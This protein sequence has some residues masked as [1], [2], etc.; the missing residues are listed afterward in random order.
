MPLECAKVRTFVTSYALCRL[1][2]LSL[3]AGLSC[4]ADAE[5]VRMKNGDVIH[6]DRVTETSSN[7]RYEIGDDS[8][9]VPRSKVERIEAGPSMPVRQSEL[10]TYVP[11]T[12]ATGERELLEQ[13]VHEGSVNRETLNSIESRGN[14][15]VT[16]VAFY[17]AGKQEFQSGKYAE[18]RRY[19]E[20]GMHY[21]PQNP[22]IINFYAALLIRTGRAKEA[23][24]YAAR[25]VRLAPDSPDALVVLGVAQYSSGKSKEAAESWKQ[26]LALRPDASVQ[27]LLDRANR[28]LA[29]ESNYSERE[30][31]HFTLR[32]EGAQS[33]DAL[34]SQILSTLESAYAELSQD[35]GIEP[36]YSVQVILYTNK[37]FFDVTHAPSWTGALND[38]KLRIPLQG[39]DSVTPDLARILKHELAHSF[40]NQI[41]MG[42]CPLWLNEGIAQAM[43]PRSL[44]SN[45][46]TL[47]QLF[48]QEHEIP[49]NALEGSFASFSGS[50]AALAYDE[51]LAT[52][53]YI[54]STYGMSDILRLLERLGHG[55]S[56]ES[57]LRS[58]VHSDYRQLQNEV[59]DYLV[60]QFGN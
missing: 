22:A 49:L 30:T 51:S 50:A 38:G 9:T 18:A 14:D 53:E 20:S 42:R 55:D 37:A 12:P 47:G 35:F 56:I 52:V 26:S 33:S 29:A 2:V 4:L 54:R 58:T 36:R 27:H 16:A 39:L 40:V 46:A 21:D 23:I 48:R 6:A 57:A 28:E 13:V 41:T 17:I 15:A 3:I 8:Y 24:E 34:R 5:V 31:G 7:V 60:R 1:A 19:F 32:Y 11:N 25:A 43:E 44:T 10:P 59:G 45:G